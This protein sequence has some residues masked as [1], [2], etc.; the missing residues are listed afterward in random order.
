MISHRVAIVTGGNKGIGYEI[1][2]VLC[3][4]FEGIVYLTA[5][6]V[7][8]GKNA[9]VKLEE[10]GV[11][12]PPKFHQLDIVD[13]G[14]I[15]R[16]RDYIE[17]EY[18][19]I[20]VLINNAGMAYKR[21]STVPFSEQAENTIKVNFTGTLNVSKALFPLLKP[22]A[23]VVHV[24]SFVGL[25]ST[26][27]TSQ[28]LREQLSRPNLKELEL[29]E[30]VQESKGWPTQ[31]YGVSKLALNILTAIQA[32]DL[33]YDKSTDVLINSCCPGWC[34]TDMAGDRATKSAAEGAETPVYLALLPSGQEQPHGKF[35]SEKK[36]VSWK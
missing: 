35:Y 26:R 21:K 23:R 10:E 20:D 3:N 19:G 6:D 28:S 1:V 22:H 33:K 24:S 4:K 11:A 9:C 2:K 15:G 13:E 32:R 12:K 5:R 7:E 29:V 25:L 8:R 16:F 27:I 36:E 14:S 30:L 18:K 34:R 17:K 31:A